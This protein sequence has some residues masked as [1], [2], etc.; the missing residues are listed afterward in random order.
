M[1]VILVFVDGFGLGRDDPETNPMARPGVLE[2]LEHWL[3]CRLLAHNFPRI[4][5]LG[6]GVAVDATL[7]ISGLPQSA[8]GQVTLFTGR[9]ASA[10][11]GRHQNGF[12]GARLQRLLAK[13][14][15]FRQ[16]RA[17]GREAAFA[18]AFTAEYFAAVATGRWRY[19]ATT[20]AALAGG[21]RLR[22]LDDLMAGRAVYQDL[23]REGLRERGYD[24]PP[25]SPEDCGLTL[26]RLARDCAFCLFEYFQ[27]DI[28]GHSRDPVLPPSR[29]HQ[30]DRFLGSLL[31]AVDLS[32]DLVLVASDHGNIEDL[33][34]RSHTANPVPLLAF[35]PGQRAFLDG[36]E[37]MVQI[38]PRIM[39]AIE[40]S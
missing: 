39:A 15:I 30:L 34:T 7:G 27:T 31:S 36:L 33:S 2:N 17:S 38:T 8:T 12:P 6:G 28:A 22:F 40:A 5:A 3:G 9:N 11:L 23:T 19:S 32:R 4:T 14:S 16:V 29:L 26:A 1:G 13:Y 25:A 18:N 37:S 20:L 35:G 10:L 21:V 24:V